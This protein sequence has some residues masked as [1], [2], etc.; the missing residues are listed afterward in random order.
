MASQF[1][2]NFSKSF[3][4]GQSYK[5]RRGT[6]N[7]LTFYRSDTFATVY[8]PGTATRVEIAR[9]VGGLLWKPRR[10]KLCGTGRRTRIHQDGSTIISGA[11]L[12]NGRTKRPHHK[13]HLL[14]ESRQP[15]RV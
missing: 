1:H 10:P 3:Q 4:R 11:Y 8:H 6:I 14:P 7:M 5:V 2:P 15:E 13:Q 12:T 9:E